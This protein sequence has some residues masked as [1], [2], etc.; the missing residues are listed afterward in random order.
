MVSG[1]GSAGRTVYFF[2]VSGAVL[3]LFYMYNISI[4]TVQSQSR[5]LKFKGKKYIQ[6]S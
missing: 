5:S 2:P 1:N 6:G 4:T 3:C